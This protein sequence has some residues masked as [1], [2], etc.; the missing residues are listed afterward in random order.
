VTWYVVIFVLLIRAHRK[1][2]D[3]IPVAA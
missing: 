1:T 3:A 2:R